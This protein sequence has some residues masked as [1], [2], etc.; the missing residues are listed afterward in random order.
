MVS[1]RIE[2]GRSELD[3]VIKQGEE[4]VWNHAFQ[5]FTIAI[6]KADP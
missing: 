4:V 5:G 2:I 3:T 6:T 1:G